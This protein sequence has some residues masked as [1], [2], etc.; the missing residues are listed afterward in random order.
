MIPQAAR[1]NQKKRLTV[2]I[3]EQKLFIQ[4][5]QFLT[6]NPTALL[7]SL[8][9][10]FHVPAHRAALGEGTCQPF[11][12]PRGNNTWDCSPWPPGVPPTRLRGLLLSLHLC[13][14]LSLW[15][16][17][18]VLLTRPGPRSFSPLG[19]LPATRSTA[20]EPLLC[21]LSSE[22]CP[23]AQVPQREAPSPHNTQPAVVP[24][25]PLRNLSSSSRS[26]Q[27]W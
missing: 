10:A 11:P 17:P 26:G 25:S 20:P 13:S 15:P 19:V 16:A 6:A 12:H 14:S 21:L 4:A 7:M 18:H 24:P 9:P 5:L 22:G 27:A 3:T 1:R 23:S 2:D 8:Q